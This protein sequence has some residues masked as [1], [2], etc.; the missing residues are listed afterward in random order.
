MTDLP[1]GPI[2]VQITGLRELL[3]AAGKA[4]VSADDMKEAMASVAGLVGDAAR[5]LARRDSGT[6]AGTIRPGRSKN[7]AVVRAGTAGVPYAGVQH[8]GWPAHNITPNPFLTDALT[9][10][11]AAVLAELD[12]QLSRLLAGAGL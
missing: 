3:R 6:M 1:S 10:H 7:K 2:R 11:Q 5:P 8:Y 12:R 9:T 4:G